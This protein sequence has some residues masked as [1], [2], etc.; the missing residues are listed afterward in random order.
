[1][2]WRNAI[3]LKMI[4][5]FSIFISCSDKELDYCKMLELDQSFVNSDTTDL[6][7]FNENRSKRKQLIKKNFNDIIEYSD[8]FGFPEMGNLN[9][10]GI[11][12]CRNWAVFITCFHIGQIEPQ[13]F[14]EHETVEVLSREIQRGNLESSSLFT[15]LREG[16]RNHKFCE[17]Q[18][19]FILQTLEKWNIRIEEL[20]TIKFEHCH[21]KFKY[22]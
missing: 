3:L 5:L 10:S 13:L 17:S 2:Y 8:Q 18:K 21:N 20:P 11:D 16:F 4:L 19:D 6:E 15:S 22:I 14:F 12:S 1:M 9:V 7:K